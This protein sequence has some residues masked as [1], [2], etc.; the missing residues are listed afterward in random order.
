MLSFHTFA[1]AKWSQQPNGNWRSAG[2][3]VLSNDSYQRM[4]S[5]IE[6]AKG[7]ASSGTT[8]RDGASIAP[9]GERGHNVKLPKDPRRLNIDQANAALEQMG[10]KETGSRFDLKTQTSYITLRFP[11]GQTKEVTAKD[12]K[13]LVY[14]KKPGGNTPGANPT[15]PT[16]PTAPKPASP[17]TPQPTASPSPAQ[18]PQPQPPKADPTPVQP[19]TSPKG[20]PPLPPTTPEQSKY[21]NATYEK[22]KAR[23]GDKVAEFLRKTLATTVGMATAMNG[24]AWGAIAGTALAGPLGL[25]LGTFLG[26]GLG[27]RAGSWAGKKVDKALSG[28]GRGLAMARAAGRKILPAVAAGTAAGGALVG[29]AVATAAGA[30]TGGALL[31][32]TSGIAGIE[33]YGAA[34]DLANRSPVA[35]RRAQRDDYRAFRK[36]NGFSESAPPNLDPVKLI[37][38]RLKALFVKQGIDKEP[39]DKQILAALAMVTKDLDNGDRQAKLT[40]MS[41]RQLRTIRRLTNG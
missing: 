1:R 2:G 8:R 6:Q 27:A 24:F 25:A 9:E 41:E 38:A 14:G 23:F 21:I 33:A 20:A 37:R 22:D 17:T 26:G 16:P 5:R 3:R 4:M 39:D 35:R 30:P 7:K 36:R 10:Y 28:R 34:K 11:D 18:R 31:G 29:G 13:K 40:A 32:A 15:S 19:A 12:V